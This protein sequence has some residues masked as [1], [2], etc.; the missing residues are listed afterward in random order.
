MGR[1]TYTVA[2]LRSELENVDGDRTVH[3]VS[4]GA[5]DDL[6]G[7]SVEDIEWNNGDTEPAVNLKGR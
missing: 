1:E 4:Q 6:V 2:E 7:V 5:I 3:M